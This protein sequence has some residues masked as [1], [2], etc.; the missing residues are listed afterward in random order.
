MARQPERNAGRP[1]ADRRPREAVRSRRR[2][3]ALDL[4]TKAAAAR[5]TGHVVAARRCPRSGCGRWSC[6]TAR[7]GC[8]ACGG[9][10]T[11]RPS[12]CPS[13][14]RSPPPGTPHWPA[15]PAPPRPGGPPQGRPRP[16]RPDRQPAP[17]PA[18]RPPLRG[19]QRGPATSPA[20]RRR[21]RHAACRRAASA[22][23]SSTSSPTT[24]RP[25]ASPS[26]TCVSARALRELYLAPFE[27][28][29]EN[30]HPW[31]IMTAYNSGQRHDDDRAPL[32]GQRGPARRVGLR[33]LQRLRLDGRPLAPSRAIE[34]GLDV[35][36]PG[37]RTVY[38]DAARRRRPRR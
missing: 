24:P 28:I 36:M 1:P 11:T 14:P 23:P 26:T 15:A 34:G 31:G 32:P 27:A 13:P 17:L 16:A 8:A 37:P 5:R 21:I 20:D 4:D 38:G 7:S 19:V 18:R 29:V 2:S 9:P 12:P 10:P 22:P 6:P 30:A 33:R 3:R 35:A 25:T